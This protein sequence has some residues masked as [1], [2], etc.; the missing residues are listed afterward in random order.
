[1]IPQTYVKQL[2]MDLSWVVSKLHGKQTVYTS[3]EKDFMLQT[4]GRIREV[5][6]R[7]LQVS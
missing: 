4:L 5:I 7:E 1:M 2:L 6:E 3:T